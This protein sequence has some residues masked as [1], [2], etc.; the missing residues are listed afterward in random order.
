MNPCVLLKAL[1]PAKGP[2]QP[3]EHVFW[4]TASNLPPAFIRVFAKW[5]VGGS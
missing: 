1:V 3:N 4:L 2:L 5:P